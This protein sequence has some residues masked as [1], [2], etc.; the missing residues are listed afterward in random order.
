M[1]IVPKV[2]IFMPAYN[3]G[4]YIHDA[5][6]SLSRQTFQNFVV[7]IVDD[8]STD[9]VTPS[10]L[11][12]IHYEKAKVYHNTNNKGVAVRAREHFKKFKTDYILVLCADDIL[13]P[14]FL[15]KTVNFL[16]ENPDYGAVGTNIRL[17]DEDPQQPHAE[18]RY[19]EA[20][21]TLPQILAHNYILGSSLMRNKA[22]QSANLTGGFVRYQ[23][24]DRWISIL[25]AGWKIGLV[26]E[27]LFYYRQ[28]GDSLSHSATVEEELEMRQKL[29]KKHIQS[30]TAHCEQVI[31]NMERAF[32]EMQEGKNWLDQQY[33]NHI[34][35]ISR[36]QNEITQL[37][38]N[39]SIIYKI[40][41]YIVHKL[42][43]GNF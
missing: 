10:I 38:K 6:D 28:H 41:R 9:G 18:K 26:P 3:Q 43:K 39:T 13:E 21:M 11:A 17:F 14:K 8:G 34:A 4:K 35:E 25:E 33:K 20:K 23:D 29:L 22:L 37:K 30:Y 31:L 36:L 42:N 27:F 1:K 15:E 32:L 19:D 7:H 16:E 40:K 2:G 12:D 24:W 5:L